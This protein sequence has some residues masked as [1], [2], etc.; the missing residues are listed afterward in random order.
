MGKYCQYFISSVTIGIELVRI[1]MMIIKTMMKMVKVLDGEAVYALA[2]KC[3]LY[4]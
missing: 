2:Y 4:Y 3:A 1:R